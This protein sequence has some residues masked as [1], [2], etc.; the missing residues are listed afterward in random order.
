[1]NLDYW[2]VF[3][4]AVLVAVIANASGFSGGVL[5]QP[6]F[7][8]VL[9]LPLQQSIATG[10]GTETIGMS[11]GAYRYRRMSAS[12][13]SSPEPRTTCAYQVGAIC[14]ITRAADGTAPLRNRLSS[15]S[16]SGR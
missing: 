5:F 2:F 8:F 6:F 1:M 13:S 3:P 7:N 15:A 10:I 12:S 11:S 9:Q 4:C 14:F 16:S